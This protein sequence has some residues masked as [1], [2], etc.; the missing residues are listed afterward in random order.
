MKRKWRKTLSATM[1][2]LLAAAPMGSIGTKTWAQENGTLITESEMEEILAGDTGTSATVR[3]RQSV[4]DPSIVADDGTYYVFGS[5]MGTAKTTDLSNWELLYSEN[6]ADCGLFGNAAGETVSYEEA[7]KENAYQGTVSV[8]RADGTELELDFGTYDAAAWIEDNTV[9]GNMWAPDVIY[10]TTMNKWCMYLSLNG[11]NWDSTII[12]LTADDVEG[13]YVYQGPVVFTGFSTADSDDSFHD[14]DLELVLGDLDELPEKYRQRTDTSNGTWGEWWPHAI[15]P[16]VFYGDDGKLWLAYGSWS[17]GICMLELDENTGLRDYTVVYDSDSDTLGKSYTSDAYFGKRIAGGYYVSGEGPYIQKIG[18]YYYL[19]MSY[20]F[21]SPE[22]GYQMRIFRSENPDGPYVDAQ[23][24]SACYTGY[25]HNY[26]GSDTRGERL[27]AGYKWDSMDVAEVAQGH[28]SAFVDTDGKAYVIY[29]TKFADGTAS[30]ELRVHQLFVNEDGWLVAAPYEYDGETLSDSGYEVSQ[31][32]GE[33]GTILHSYVQDYAGLEYATPQQIVLNEDGSITGSYTGT[34]SVDADS[35]NIELVMDGHT[36][37]GVLIE[38][39]VD[40]ENYSTLCFTAVNEEGLCI[41][42]AMSSDAK[43]IIAQNVKNFDFGVPESTYTDIEL[44]T[45]GNSGA[46]I[47]WSSSDESVISADGTVAANRTE[48]VQV[49]LTA[50]IGKGSYYYLLDFPVTVKAGDG[51][52]S[53]RTLIASYFTDNPQDLSVVMDGSLSVANPFYDGTTH[54]IDISGGV[55]VEFDVEKTGDLHMLGTILAFLGSGRLYF[56]PGSYLGYNATGGYFDA[57]IKDWSLVQDYIGDGA[58]VKLEFLQD[59]FGVYVDGTLVYDEEIV[60]TENGGGTLT[61]YTKVLK[62]L[63]E[64]AE[65]LYFGYGSWWASVGDDEA[66]CTI[67]NVECYAE[68]T[69][70]SSSTAD[71]VVWYE[72]DEV[73]LASSDAITYEENPFYGEETDCLYL[74]YTINFASDAAKN[75]WDGVM[76]FFNSSTSGRISVQTNPYICFN[77]GDGNWMDLNNPSNTANGGTNWA[78]SAE[79]GTDYRVEILITTS[80]VTMSVDG[81]TIAVSVAKANSD[82]TYKLL[83]DAL[84]DCDMLTWGVGQAV[85]SYW[86]TELCTL[87]NIVIASSPNLVE[88]SEDEIDLTTTDYLDTRTNPFAGK[89]ILGMDLEYTLQFAS[90][91]AK[92][93]WDGIF[94][95]YQT[96]SGG[97]VSMQTNPYLCFNSGSGTWMD[98]NNPNNVASG[99]TN[100]AA[101]TETGQDYEVSVKIRKDGVTIAIDGEELSLSE[102]S[103]SSDVTAEEIL[104]FISD[105]DTFTFG[106]G[107]AQTAYWNTELATIKNFSA[108]A[109]CSN[110]TESGND[111]TDDSDDSSGDTETGSIVVLSE[112]SWKI[113]KSDGILYLDNPAAGVEL[114]KIEIS[115][116]ILFASDAVKNGWDGLFSFYDETTGARVSIQSAPYICYNDMGGEDVHWADINSPALAGSTDWAALAETGETYHVEIT[117]TADEVTLQAAGETLSYADSTSDNFTGYE[118]ILNLIADCSKLTIGVGTAETAF[119]NSELCTISNFTVTVNGDDSDNSGSSDSSGNS[120]DDSGNSGDDSGNSGSGDSGSSSGDDSDNSGS[121]DSSGEE[122]SETE[123]TESEETDSET[124]ETESAEADSETEDSETESEE[125]DSET[126]ET[127]SETT[128]SNDT[129][130]C[131][132]TSDGSETTEDS[133]TTEEEVPVIQGALIFAPD[134]KKDTVSDEKEQ[135]TV[136]AGAGLTEKTTTKDT[137]KEQG[138]TIDSVEEKQSRTITSDKTTAVFITGDSSLLPEGASLFWKV[139]TDGSTY[140]KAVTA[141]KQLKSCMLCQVM[142]LKLF[143]DKNL[144][145]HQLDGYVSVTVP[146]PDGV[147]ET[148]KLTVYRLEED[149]SLTACETEVSDGALTFQTNH[150]STFVV[151]KETESHSFE[152][153]LLVVLLL[154][155]GAGGYLFLRRKI[156][157]FKVQSAK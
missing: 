131:S 4:H 36:Y 72:K 27:M 81:E 51:T 73:T 68:T 20:G 64:S 42:G 115:Y 43:S 125:A 39:K 26:N 147:A 24:N 113:Q 71:A 54:G 129:T 134:T 137:E 148:A 5:H 153:V 114:E 7:F 14:T 55:S 8:C 126:E 84:S 33:Y 100:W 95:F 86:W 37:R 60:S 155:A 70:A 151:T 154:V 52:F 106:V 107:L 96:T 109:V 77:A 29:H 152:M 116:D 50:T 47:S 65:T 156:V 83:L 120:G 136:V 18:N 94:S 45:E 85:T 74:A 127:E 88:L 150:F 13:P 28:N 135:E 38:Q 117:L 104:S 121:S 82:S 59:G 56:T 66:N 103:S 124:E 25:V 145:L 61:D 79:T 15:D 34:W 89:E 133:E 90:D 63:N 139:L 111:D 44:P 98:L 32:T 110:T 19:F 143:D 108:K 17:G 23:G 53:E 128:D 3:T 49:T 157:P 130:V 132:E 62:W 12:L 112:N 101:S 58:H 93:G 105:C 141:A 46:V 99:G 123:E 146:L 119:W 31:V 30:H 21:Y 2:V 78:A 144:A 102:A 149:G 41:W 80:G 122:N 35:P 67:S 75:G 22:G 140:E 92:N 118:E 40:N 1:A 142:E 48:D 97:R 91:A 57:N 69:T 11:A 9:S 10:N 16:T 138:E 6:N 87:S 76:S